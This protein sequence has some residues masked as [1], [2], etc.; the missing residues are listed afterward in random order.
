V[1]S[2]EL[3][4]GIVADNVRVQDEEGCVVLAEDVLCELKRA[5][6]A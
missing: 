6:G 4:E 3:G 5:G 2:C 1:E